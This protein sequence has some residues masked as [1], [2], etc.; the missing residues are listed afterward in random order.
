MAAF[1]SAIA[2]PGQLVYRAAV[3]FT[4][5]PLTVSSFGSAKLLT[6]QAP[7]SA[8]ADRPPG[9]Y[10]AV[11]GLGA[12]ATTRSTLYTVPD[13]T[14][15]FIRYASFTNNSTGTA[16]VQLWL[17][18]SRIVSGLAIASSEQKV[19]SVLWVLKAGQSVEV[20][21]N[22]AGVDCLLTGVEEVR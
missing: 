20:Q 3:P 16:T 4:A 2:P 12:V 19:D 17:A 1:G 7:V 22:A 9:D 10:P 8:P 18:G 11:Y 13:G 6:T 21:S 14:T 5:S 15:A